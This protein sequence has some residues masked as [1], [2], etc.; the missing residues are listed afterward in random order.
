MRSLAVVYASDG[1][2]LTFKKYVPRGW[3]S[4]QSKK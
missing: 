2:A 1:D 3:S 4:T